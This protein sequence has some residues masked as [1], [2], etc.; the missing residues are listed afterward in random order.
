MSPRN[1]DG[2]G[3][4][5]VFGG[6]KLREE[7]GA[8][9]VWVDRDVVSVVFHVLLIFVHHQLGILFY[10]PEPRGRATPFQLF[11]S[12]SSPPPHHTRYLRFGTKLLFLHNY[13]LKYC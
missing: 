5:E 11:F 12:L 2:G 7:I 9:R 4:G 13:V 1:R 6:F 3:G 10:L 8:V